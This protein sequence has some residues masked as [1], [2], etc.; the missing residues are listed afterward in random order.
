MKQLKFI[1]IK[2][3]IILLFLVNSILIIL[4][5]VLNF[6]GLRHYERNISYIKNSSLSQLSLLRRIEYNTGTNYI[7][8][9]HNLY[10]TEPEKKIFY[11]IK[12]RELLF[13]NDSLFKELTDKITR[14]S[15]KNS[16]EEVLKWKNLYQK[17][18]ITALEI[19]WE[20]QDVMPFE[21][22]EHEIRPLAG[23]YKQKLEDFAQLVVYNTEQ[24]I[25]TTLEKISNTRLLSR[26]IVAFGIL[27]L[28]LIS[29]LMIRISK[30]LTKDYITLK[31]QTI[32]REK[33]QKELQLL[34]E[35]LEEKVKKRTEELNGAYENICQYNDELKEVT[36]AKDKFISVISHDLRNPINTI[37][38]SSEILM[39]MLKES[40]VNEQIK[41][42]AS[43][44]NNSSNK[45]IVQLNELL[46]WAKI[47]N[48]SMIFNPQKLNLK[49]TVT[50]SFKL[51]QSNAEEKYIE[52]LNEVPGNI[53][54]K[55]DKLMLRS[56]FQNLVTNAIKFTLQGGSVTVK[57]E[58]N[59]EFVII[60]VTD[61]GIGM[62]EIIKDLLFNE[63]KTVSHTGTAMEH[64]SGLGLVLVKDFVSTHGGTITV[65][66]EIDKGSTFTFTIPKAGR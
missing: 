47:K 2:R 19:S 44:I 6:I 62:T 14:S 35:E 52:L 37:L 60:N 4:L 32:E 53:F 11:A 13:Q 7:Y 41:H 8:L 38:S 43:I 1:P 65:D 48:K 5:G 39:N 22:E 40:P 15:T 12:I 66:S 59:A 63:S 29:N 45:L 58:E 54:V 26:L 24:D 33:A 10:S 42:F 57:A 56:I 9:L 28:L 30:R 3:Q 61:T 49:E 17:K 18:L 31:Q 34:N 51:I 25:T 27:F 50:E 20:E 21:Y 16:L 64:G 23:I 55:A 46:E 36:Q